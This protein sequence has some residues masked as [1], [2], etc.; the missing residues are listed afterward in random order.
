MH[1][2]GS[3]SVNPPTHCQN[4]T[5]IP[6]TPVLDESM[7]PAIRM[8]SQSGGSRPAVDRELWCTW[9]GT[10][11]DNRCDGR[12]TAQD[13]SPP[14][15]GKRRSNPNTATATERQP[16]PG[17]ISRRNTWNRK[18]QAQRE[19]K[20]DRRPKPHRHVQGLQVVLQQR[21]PGWLLIHQ[22][23]GAAGEAFAW[24]QG[25]FF[26]TRTVIVQ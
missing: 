2:R 21:G 6:V 1:P 19:Q 12:A 25:V 16:G 23:H 24:G 14:G 3:S 9:R 15:I 13:A 11:L 4:P 26:R 20:P 8:R 5:G 18:G 22:Q 17:W 10:G 7:A